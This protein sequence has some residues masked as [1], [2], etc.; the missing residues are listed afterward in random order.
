M[1][2]AIFRVRC[3]SL[4]VFRCLRRVVCCNL[5]NDSRSVRTALSHLKCPFRYV[6]GQVWSARENR[7]IDELLP[8]VKSKIHYAFCVPDLHLSRHC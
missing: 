5:F 6:G 8:L 3:E 4:L 7:L 1:A 2:F